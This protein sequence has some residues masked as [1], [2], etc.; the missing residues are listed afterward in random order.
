MVQGLLRKF[1]RPDVGH[2]A[3]E[4]VRIEAGFIH[5]DQADRREMIAEG[6]EVSLRIRIKSLIQEL[7]DDLSLDMQRA[8]GNIHQTIQPV[9]NPSRVFGLISNPRHVDRNDADGAGALAGTEEAA[10]FLAQ[11]AEVQT[12]TAAHGADI[13]RV[14]VAVDVV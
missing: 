1:L 2:V 3:A 13:A 10:G 7:R 12:Q 5:A 8:C 9:E 4:P 11:L 6:S 14:H